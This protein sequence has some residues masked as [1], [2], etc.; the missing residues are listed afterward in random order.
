MTTIARNTAR[1][2]R[3]RLACPADAAAVCAIYAPYVRDTATTFDLEPPTVEEMGQKIATILEER[4]FLVAEIERSDAGAASAS[5]H[6]EACDSEAFAVIGYS[7]ASPFRPRKAYLHS[8]ET[9]IY[10]APEAKGFGLGTRLYNALEEILRLQ[11]VYNANACVT[12]IEPADE[13]CPSTSRIFHERRG[14]V[15]CAHIPN[16]GHKFGRWYDILWLQ[17]Q[18]IPLSQEPEGF[19]P[20]PQ[21]DKAAIAAILEKA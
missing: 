17:K 12:C 21:V 5:S 11:N 4:P 15:Q 19:V 13:T 6:D 1:E 16:C 10:L 7:Y 2:T 9:S 3:I 14:Y 20:L 8:I 18:L